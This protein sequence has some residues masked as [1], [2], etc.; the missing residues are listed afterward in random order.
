M[1]GSLLQIRIDLDQNWVPS[2][3]REGSVGCLCFIITEKVII[4][5][6]SHYIKTVI[7]SEIIKASRYFRSKIIAFVYY[8]RKIPQI[9][10][11]HLDCDYQI[12]VLKLM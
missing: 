10:I 5:I 3:T 11:I 12:V 6:I 1:P 2:L 9:Y 8:Q 4:I 7:I